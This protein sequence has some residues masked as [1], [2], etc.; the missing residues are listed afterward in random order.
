LIIVHGVW[1]SSE[2]LASWL[3]RPQS[4]ARCSAVL[5]YLLCGIVVIQSL[6]ML[7]RLYHVPKQDLQAAL[8][9][10]Q[11]QRKSTDRVATI[12]LTSDVYRRYY[13]VDWVAV[14][15][16]S[17][18]ESLAKDGARVWVVT[19]FPIHLKS[20]YPELSARLAE[21][22]RPVRVFPG[23]LG[24]GEVQVSLWAP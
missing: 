15:R 17:E 20:R 12:G 19:S 10:V 24:G 5:S 22:I 23:T 7:P 9:F 4:R 8:Q 3:A 1:G 18:L 6:R 13:H 2:V 11:Q 14:E 21:D 16:Q